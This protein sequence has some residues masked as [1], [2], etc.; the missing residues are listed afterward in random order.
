M[1]NRDPFLLKENH[2]ISRMPYNLKSLAAQG[3]LPPGIPVD[4]GPVI[5]KAHVAGQKTLA[6]RLDA[7][8]ILD[9]HASQ[10]IQTEQPQLVI[11]SIRYVV[12]KLRSRARSDSD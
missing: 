12:D 4:F 6:E 5:F 10:Y 2:H 11:N 3:S 1:F 8:L 9:T 7:K